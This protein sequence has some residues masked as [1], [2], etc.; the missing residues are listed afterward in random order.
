MFLINQLMG[1]SFALFSSC[2]KGQF[3]N[4]RISLWKTKRSFAEY[5]WMTYGCHN[6]G[7]NKSLNSGPLLA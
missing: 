3:D 4:L 6:F 2:N 5:F 7:Y 1:F